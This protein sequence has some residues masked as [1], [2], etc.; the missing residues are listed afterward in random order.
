MSILTKEH[1]TL[2][3]Q[4]LSGIADTKK[5]IA[6]AKLANIDVSESEK[7]L[8]ESETKLLAIKRVY[9]PAK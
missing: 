8:L 9:F 6:K 2:I 5:E 4:A 1:L 3:N 7:S